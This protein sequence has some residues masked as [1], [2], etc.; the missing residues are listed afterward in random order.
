MGVI[1]VTFLNV[2][3]FSIAKHIS[4]VSLDIE[5]LRCTEN[6]ILGHSTNE[7]KNVFFQLWD[8]KIM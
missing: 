8:M 5:L 7:E 4:S 2:V 3:Y 6:I 1:N